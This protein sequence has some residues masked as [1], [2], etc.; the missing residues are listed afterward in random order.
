M[1]D[2]IEV[3][4][5]NTGSCFMILTMGIYDSTN[6]KIVEL[7]IKHLLTENCESSKIYFIY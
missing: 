6:A 3:E 1:K 4:T 5:R 7:F 2:L